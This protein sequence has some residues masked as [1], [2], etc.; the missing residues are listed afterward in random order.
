MRLRSSSSSAPKA[1]T[2]SRESGLPR[3]DVIDIASINAGASEIE[4]HVRHRH[5][6]AQADV[7]VGFGGDRAAEQ[8]LHRAALLAAG[9]AVADVP[10]ATPPRAGARGVPPP[11][12]RGRRDAPGTPV[13]AR[14]TEADVGGV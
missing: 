5:R 1:A 4:G 3:D 8:V 11:P 12:Q 10:A 9:G 2:Y 6:N 7:L 13:S 14:E